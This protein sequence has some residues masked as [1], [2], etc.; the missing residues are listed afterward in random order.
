MR[1]IDKIIVHCSATRPSQDIGAA[2]IDTWHRQQGWSEIGYHFVIRRNG[3]IENGRAV[4]KIGAHCKGHNAE[5]IG[6]CLVGGIDKDGKPENNFTDAQFTS[7]RSLAAKLQ[8][9]FPCIQSIHGHNEF[10]K[11]AC[12]CFDVKKFFSSPSLRGTK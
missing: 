2:E 9:Q 6:I 1:K 3:Q 8:V 5:S 7:L 11:K 4:E 10:A 12:P